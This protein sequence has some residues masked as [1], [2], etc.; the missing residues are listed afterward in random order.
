[1]ANK[2][3]ISVF[4]FDGT[5]IKGD[6][7]KLYCKWLS[8][9]P[10]EFFFNYYIKLIIKKL[11]NSDLDVKHER[12]R[13][14]YQ[15]QVLNKYNINQFNDILQA[16]LFEDSIKILEENKLKNNVIIV[17]ANFTTVIGDFCNRFLN[18]K[19]IANDIKNY[20]S[21]TDINFQNKVICLDETLNNEYIIKKG[22]GNS[23]G[24]HNF[25]KISEKAYL[26]LSNGKIVPWQM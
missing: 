11:F 9:N 16:N 25:M 26:R 20:N 19:L 17:S 3:T 2:L 13:Y 10:I 5:L 12:V 8:S 6:S 23:I 24:D 15:K 7:I 4:D 14:F 22:Y 18:T 21:L 1:M